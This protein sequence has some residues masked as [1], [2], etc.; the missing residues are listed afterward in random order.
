[1]ENASKALIMAATVLLGVMLLSIGVYL[2]SIFGGFSSQ[3]S[4]ALSE[5]EINEFNAQFYK[6][7]SY[8]DSEGNWQNL[9][10]A[11]DIVT[12]ANL[13]KD[14]NKKYEYDK[15][16]SYYINV[17]VSNTP[18]KTFNLKRGPKFEEQNE[19]M[20]EY[21]MKQF[22]LKKENNEPQYFRCAVDINKKT[23]LVKKV[24]FIFIK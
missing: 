19:E 10:R 15:N 14:N 21:F 13:A 3:I 8:K 4:N 1:M 7:Q 16:A 22:S 6:Y 11:Q 23:K 20:Y 9:C 5:K 18:D 2:F 12:V 17:S 24:T